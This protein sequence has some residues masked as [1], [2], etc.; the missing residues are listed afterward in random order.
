MRS[1]YL[2]M[3]GIVLTTISPA[4]WAQSQGPTKPPTHAAQK[5][6]PAAGGM[7]ADDG[8]RVFEQNCSRCHAAPDGFSP[9][10]SGTV[11]MHMRVR[12]SLSRADAQ[13][14]LRFLNP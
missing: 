14:L 6:T 4:M 1:K 3:A 12:A 9:R 5:G 2:M 8:Q 7:S 13:A 11:A 10:L